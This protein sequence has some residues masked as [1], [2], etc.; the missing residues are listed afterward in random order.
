MNIIGYNAAENVA[1]SVLRWI[2]YNAKLDVFVSSLDYNVAN[3]RKNYTL[4][5]FVV[6]AGGI[7]YLM[8]SSYRTA[9]YSGGWDAVVLEIGKMRSGNT[10]GQLLLN[11]TAQAANIEFVSNDAPDVSKV[12]AI[13]GSNSALPFTS[14]E[15]TAYNESGTAETT[16]TQST[17]INYRNGQSY[18]PFIRDNAQGGRLR[19]MFAIVKLIWNQT[20]TP[21]RIYSVFSE[22]RRYFRT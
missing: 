18:A 12:F 9:F 1:N 22:F 2:K 7:S 6:G 14:Y 5:A 17:L 3:S 11:T 10:Y 4:P 15:V 16:G 20:S 21:A 19:G 8:H 13:V